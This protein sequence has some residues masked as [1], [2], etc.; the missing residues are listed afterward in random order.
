MARPDVGRESSDRSRESRTNPDLYFQIYDGNKGQTNVSWSKS[1][2]Q[3][4]EPQ[5]IDL[6]ANPF[7]QQSS[8]FEDRHPWRAQVLN[9]AEDLRQEL[10]SDAGHLN[11][12][13]ENVR[14]DILSIKNDEESM[15][16]KNGGVLTDAEKESLM[17]RERAVAREL[18]NDYS[19]NHKGGRG[20]HRGHHG[21]HGQ[22]NDPGTPSTPGNGG[23]GQ[24]GDT[25]SGTPPGDTGTGTPPGDSSFMIGNTVIPSTVGA[26]SYQQA[27]QNF[28]ARTGIHSDVQDLYAN[29][30]LGKVPD[31]AAMQADIKAGITPMLSLR[32]TKYADVIS[33]KDDAYLKGVA[34]DLKAAGGEVL[35]RPNWEMD[36]SKNQGYGS[37]AEFI[38]SWR[39][40]HDF[41]EKQGV[42]NVK[43]VFTPNAGAYDT[44][45][46]SWAKP[47]K[48][49]YPGNDYV[50]YI[51]SDGYSGLGGAKYQTPEQVFQSGVDFANAQGKPFFIGEAGVSSSLGAATDA[52]YMRL[53]TQY[54]KAHP[55]IKGMA[56]FSEGSNDVFSSP[57]EEAAYVQMLKDLGGQSV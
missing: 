29:E 43:W 41:M 37:P 11:G 30:N 19:A 25:G 27:I 57:Q 54:L 46:P 39:Y 45:T 47:A 51:G 14:K 40:M 8:Q 2:K 24:P 53:M 5:F 26:K 20:G 49:Y 48:D 12:Q 34:D 31:L 52:N 35:L 13:Y 32:T 6:S 10:R 50:D 38:A 18:H 21:D 17:K 4:T 1:D 7:S 23:D 33:G 3:N 55:E 36:G 9:G 56:W 44:P 15:A 16:R 42:T 22:I 28:D